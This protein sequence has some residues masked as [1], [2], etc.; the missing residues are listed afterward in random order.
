MNADHMEF[1]DPPEL[2]H[3][4][5]EGGMLPEQQSS[6]PMVMGIIGIIWASLGI[7]CVPLGM[8]A[9]RFQRWG[10]E[11]Q[12]KNGQV[13]PVLETQ[14]KVAERF[15]PIMIVVLIIGFCMAVYLLTA[16]IRLVR[17]SHKARKALLTWAMLSIIMFGVNIALQILTFQVTKQELIRIGEQ[18]SLGRLYFG[19]IIGSAFAFVLGLGPPLF[20]AS[21]LSRR[22]IKEEIAG[23]R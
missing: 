15:Q 20:M 6:W 11:M 2:P 8:F 10:L 7:I 22:R 9:I 5:L 3:P 21:W 1:S 18:Q 16:C 12:Q 19:V 14:V 13:D 17:R 4:P 23:W